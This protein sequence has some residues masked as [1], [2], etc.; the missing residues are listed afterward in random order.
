MKMPTSH[1]VVQG[2]NAQALVDSKHQVILAAEAFSHQDHE[3]L[4]P[5]LDG[6]KKN[7][8]AM[9]KRQN[10]F[11]GKQLTA[12]SNYHGF[13]SLTFCQDEKAGCLHPRHPVPQTRSALCRT[14]AFQGWHS[15]QAAP[16]EKAG[17]RSRWKISN[18]MPTRQV[19]LCPQGKELTCHARNQ[20][21]RHRL[22][23]IYHA[24]PE[25]CADCPVR[26]RCLS[27]STA[28]AGISPSRWMSRS[29]T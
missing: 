5:M 18:S 15:W 19:Y 23:D 17:A 28:R 6:A 3:N 9:G 11:Q 14:G 13:D 7:L 29:R 20:R 1:G 8:V 22:Y 16:G 24:R 2:Y 27:K 12:D 21:N 25:D 26:A 4:K 10:F